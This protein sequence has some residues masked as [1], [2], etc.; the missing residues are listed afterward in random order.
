MTGFSPTF[1]AALAFAAR[2]H[3]DQVRKGT[4]VPYIVHPVQ[5]ALIL[6]R[7]GF[8]EHSAIAGLLHDAVEDTEAT[9]AEIERRFGAEVARLV[10]GVTEVKDE[11][12]ARRPWRVRKDEQLAHLAGADRDTAALKAADAL[13]N[14]QTTLVELAASGAAV[15]G[16]FNAPAGDLVWYYGQVARLCAERLGDHPLAAE[17]LAAVDELG[18]NAP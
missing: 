17:L 12:G 5:V 3:R 18:R 9:L 2:A 4:D 15:W 11:G 13:H 10:D 1:D 6:I 8:E 14:A 7:H 16:R